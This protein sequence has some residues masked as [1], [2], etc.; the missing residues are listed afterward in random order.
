MRIKLE[1][2]DWKTFQTTKHPAQPA[3]PCTTMPSRQQRAQNQISITNPAEVK[4]RNRGLWPATW[5]RG[6]P[7][8]RVY[9]LLEYSDEGRL[10]TL[11]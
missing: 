11:S 6:K 9:M 8:S 7:P 10:L 1:P 2:K 3:H 5:L 4:Q